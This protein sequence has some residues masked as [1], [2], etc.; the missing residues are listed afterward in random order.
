M[1][2]G[3]EDVDVR[4][5]GRGRPF[6]LTLH[7]PHRT[8]LTAAELRELEE[9]ALSTSGGAVAIRELCLVHKSSLQILKD[10]EADKRKTYSCIVRASRR[11]EDSELSKLAGMT[12]VVLAQDTPLRVL[13]RRSPA[14]R[15]KT[16]HSMLARRLSDTYFRLQLTT[17]AGTYV[18]EFVH[19][20]LGRTRPHL[21][22]LLGENCD[23]DLIELDVVDVQL[24]WPPST[25]ADVPV[26]A[27]GAAAGS[28]RSAPEDE[29]GE[30]EDVAE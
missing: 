6:A 10:G 27:E 1:A 9:K 15:P 22:Q 26:E 11:V 19:G 17:Q 25:P 12:D 7:D 23:T 4:M 2:A 13:H 5:L 8:R 24:A 29:Q 20:D 14:T 21:G 3:R 28:K 16:V 18:K 30:D